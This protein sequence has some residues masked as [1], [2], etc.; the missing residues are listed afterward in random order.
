MDN[1]QAASFIKMVRG[2]SGGRW[3]PDVLLKARQLAG[4]VL[5]PSSIVGGEYMPF[6]SAGLTSASKVL[7]AIRMPQ[8]Q[9]APEVRF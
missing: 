9:D 1:M 6:S 4:R 7:A 3:T 8:G 5:T 2:N